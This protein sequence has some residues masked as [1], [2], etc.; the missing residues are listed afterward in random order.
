MAKRCLEKEIHCIILIDYCFIQA[1]INK[2]FV[3]IQRKAKE[4]SNL[5]LNSYKTPIPYTLMQHH[6]YIQKA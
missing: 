4:F 2:K 5:T 6:N 3:T 1:Q